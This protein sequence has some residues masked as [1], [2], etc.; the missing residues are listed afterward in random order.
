MKAIPE[1]NSEI[2]GMQWQG[3]GKQR[4]IYIHEYFGFWVFI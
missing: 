1:E 2:Y 3:P 4:L